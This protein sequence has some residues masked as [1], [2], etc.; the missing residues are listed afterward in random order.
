MFLWCN[1]YPIQLISGTEVGGL[2]FNPFTLERKIKLKHGKNDLSLLSVTVGLK[3]SIWES[4]QFP[5][6]KH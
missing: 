2:H 3:V 1:S 4:T 5:N 6:R